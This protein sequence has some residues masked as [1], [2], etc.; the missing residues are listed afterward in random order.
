MD[1]QSGGLSFLRNGFDGTT[2]IHVVVGVI[3]ILVVYHFVFH[4]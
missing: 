1:Q 2:A 3:L 4:R